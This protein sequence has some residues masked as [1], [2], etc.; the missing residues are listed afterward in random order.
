[1]SRRQFGFLIGFLFVWL[2]WA[3]SWVVVGAVATGLL[4]YLAVR[5]LEGD[6]VFDWDTVT[7]RFR[8]QTRR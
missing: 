2:A 6:L 8:D 7:D 4:A 5:V 3:A 1:M